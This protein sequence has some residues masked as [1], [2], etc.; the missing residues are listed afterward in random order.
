MDN[1]KNN[2]TFLRYFLIALF[3]IFSYFSFKNFNE[4]YLFLKEINK[5]DYLKNPNMYYS[6]SLYFLS[7]LNIIISIIPIKIYKNKKNIIDILFII[8]SAIL[9]YLSIFYIENFYMENFHLMGIGG[10]F[11]NPSLPLWATSYAILILWFIEKK[12]WMEN[13]FSIHSFF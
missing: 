1:K 12:E 5:N 7:I 9:L 10:K 6:Y 13:K 2:I 11:F 8:F 3:F 4:Y